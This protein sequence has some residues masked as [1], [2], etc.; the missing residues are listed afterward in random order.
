MDKDPPG[1]FRRKNLLESSDSREIA[2]GQRLWPSIP[3]IFF[4]PWRKPVL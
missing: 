1:L 4:V 3:C 2:L